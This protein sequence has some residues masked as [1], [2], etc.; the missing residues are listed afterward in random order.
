[1]LNNI[2]ALVVI[3][4]LSGV[5]FVIARP[6]ACRYMSVEAFA[7]RRNVWLALTVVG[8]ISP[9][10]WAYALFAMALL[11][12][13]ARRDENP[14]AL[15]V[16]VAFTVPN[17]RF[18]IPG[19]LV[20][21][22]FDLTQF[23]ILSLVILLP[24]IVSI[25]RN[26]HSKRRFR[27]TDSLLV[28]FLTL[29][30]VLLMP[31]ESATNTMR[32]SFLFMIDTFF[33]LYAFSRL[34]DQRKIVDVMACFWLSCA[35]MA[36][37]ALFETGKGWLLYTGLAN[38]WGDPNA[39]A[40]LMRGDSLRAQAAAGH[41]IRLGYLLAM[42]IGFFMYL[43][44]LAPQQ[45]FSW[46]FFAVFLAAVFVTGSRAAWVT[47]AMVLVL[48]TLLRP[49]FGKQLTILIVGG[50]VAF[51]LMY[52]T[53]LKE[54]VLDRLPIL[55]SSDQDS[56][57]YRQE[58]ATVSWQ[59]IKQNPWFGDPW[60]YLQMESL[61]QGQGIIDIVNGYLYTALF[62]GI[63][64]VM[65]QVGVLLTALG[66][67]IRT[68]LAADDEDTRLIG[69]ALVACMLATLFFIGTAG[70][71]MM[72]YILCGLLVSYRSTFAARTTEHWVRR[73]ARRP[74]PTHIGMSEPS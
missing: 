10:F 59:L 40:W 27:W 31:Y 1:M 22:L 18:Y 5:V 54:A 9:Y 6:L 2:K 29:Q 37:I 70:Y 28:A 30:V 47:A 34:T 14:L 11:F 12:W 23:R 53:P 58:L 3:L 21:Q 69:S 66:Y 72:T 35:T 24:L 42:G 67:G 7:R 43:R 19:I 74:V 57:E 64:G 17:V 56:V 41:S 32:R 8:F 4:V 65:L 49:G 52:V 36:V 45:S 68:V 25:W 15:F 44:R 39:F 71:E 51:G 46:I 38:T 48:A 26:D 62:S 60:V 33:V 61:R 63:V 55:G 20:N 13:A 50:L 16:L 73:P